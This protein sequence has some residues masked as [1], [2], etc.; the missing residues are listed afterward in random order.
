MSYA[1]NFTLQIRPTIC[2]TQALQRRLARDGLYV[3]RAR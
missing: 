1:E 3:E 2:N